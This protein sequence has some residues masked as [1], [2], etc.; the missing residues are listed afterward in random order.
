MA[1]SNALSKIV[2]EA[3]R[4]RKLHPNKHREWKGF[5]KEAGE[6]YRSGKIGSHKAAK[7]KKVV[8]HHKK[9]KAATHRKKAVGVVKRKG[10]GKNKRH[11]KR[12]H[13]TRKRS[14]HKRRRMAGTG[15]RSRGNN[16][17]GGGGMME[18]LL[19]VLVLGG[20]GLIAYEMFKD[21]GTQ[22]TQL[23]AGTPPLQLTTNPT[24]NAQAQNIVAYAAAGGL[25]VDAIIKLIQALNSQSDSGVS[26]VYDN[27]NSTGEIPGYL[28]A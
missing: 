17:G 21:K 2:R 3:K 15:N 9:R 22:P 26:N 12:K 13:V 23:P 10:P 5:V 20:L 19:P 16:G 11:V 18:K 4:L 7:K 25:A 6:K 14:T 1:K 24:R 28:L 8:R 27:I